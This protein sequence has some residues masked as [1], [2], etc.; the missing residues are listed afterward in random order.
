MVG[1]G[2]RLG[3][4]FYLADFLSGELAWGILFFSLFLV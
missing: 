4:E 2:G 3:K 1:K